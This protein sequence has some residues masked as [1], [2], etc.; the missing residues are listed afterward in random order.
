MART[1]RHLLA[2]G[3][4]PTQSPQPAETLVTRLHEKIEEIRAELPSK[5]QLKGVGIGAPNANYF[6]GTVCGGS[7]LA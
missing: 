1:G 4:I 3:V 2:N 6:R 7:D 5:L